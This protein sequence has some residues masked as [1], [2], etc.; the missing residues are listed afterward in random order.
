MCFGSSRP[1]PQPLPPPPISGAD[2]ASIQ[3][4]DEERK[5]RA[6]A[7]GSRSTVLTGP[8]GAQQSATTQT[9]TLLG[10]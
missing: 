4:R 2:D 10:S 5:R 6:Q 8:T 7:K 3:A 1:P 9:K